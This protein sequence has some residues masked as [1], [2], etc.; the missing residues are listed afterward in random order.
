M[1]KLLWASISIILFS[2]SCK[3]K[4]TRTNECDK[5]VDTV[6]EMPLPASENPDKYDSLKNELNKR[7]QEKKKKN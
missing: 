2:T 3:T 7:R 6:L 1:R 5:Q 4:K